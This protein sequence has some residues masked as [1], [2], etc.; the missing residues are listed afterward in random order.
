[1]AKVRIN[2]LIETVHVKNTGRCAE[3]LRPGCE[4]WLTEPGSPGRKTR[5]DLVCVRKDTG[6]LFNIDSQAANQVTAEWLSE[7]GF[8]RVI[9]EYRF[10]DSRIDFYME[11]GEKRYL[12]E[13]KGCTLERDGIG[14]TRF[15]LI[16][17]RIPLSEKPWS[18]RN[19]PVCAFCSCAAMWNRTAWRS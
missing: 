7:Q 14:Y 6:V 19:G 3:L 11:K 2:G 4:V 9:S 17:K 18:R 5:Y 16:W 10:G 15:V 12:L 8:D 1:M 13:I